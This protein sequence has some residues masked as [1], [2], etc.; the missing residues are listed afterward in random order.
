MDAMP[1]QEGKTEF[2]P[3]NYNIAFNNVDFSY[4]E[5]VQTL[6]NV[7]F[8]AKQGDVTALV[9]P[10]GGGK[11]TVAK[12]SARFWDIDKGVIK[13]GGEDISRIDPETLLELL[14]NRVSGCDAVQLKRNGKYPAG[15]EGCTG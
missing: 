10:S 12:L 13:L 11:S 7:S 2:H 3:K 14:F 6:K 1:R 15:Q 8:T 9:G 4:I 5:G